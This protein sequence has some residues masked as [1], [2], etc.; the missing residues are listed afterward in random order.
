MITE[1]DYQSLRQK[2]ETRARLV[3]TLYESNFADIQKYVK[4]IVYRKKNQSKIKMHTQ[5]PI[6]SSFG[7]KGRRTCIIVYPEAFD[8]CR[9]LAEFQSVLR[10]EKQHAKDTYDVNRK[11]MPP[12]W[13]GYHTSRFLHRILP[14]PIKM[15]IL[16]GAMK[17]DNLSELHACETNIRDIRRNR[18][19][20]STEFKTYLRNKI[21]RSSD[22]LDSNP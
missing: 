5:R 3:R 11:Y 21:K 8:F 4:Q 20:F 7:L 9:N 19:D 17:K 18:D 12:F 2:H 6:L 14:Q 15:K 1:K 16:L 13:Y 10:H 22:F